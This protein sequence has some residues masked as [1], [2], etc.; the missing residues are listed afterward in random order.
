MK[1]EMPLIEDVL[2]NMSIIRKWY[3]DC[4][5][6]REY[7]RD[8]TSKQEIE[9]IKERI[10][11]YNDDI[12]IY[13]QMP[14]PTAYTPGTFFWEVKWNSKTGKSISSINWFKGSFGKTW[15]RVKGNNKENF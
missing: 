9:A 6:K 12:I 15:F 7:H 14:L 2:S 1:M 4:N 11:Y 8:D 13:K 10:S 3:Y 5:R